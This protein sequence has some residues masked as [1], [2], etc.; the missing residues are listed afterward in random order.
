MNNF[1]KYILPILEHRWDDANTT[2]A[3]MCA[4]V[5]LHW[6]NFRCKEFGW[7]ELEDDPK[8]HTQE[9]WIDDVT[10]PVIERQFLDYMASWK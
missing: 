6:M 2:D 9:E 3:G 7:P 1:Q 4:V 5:L 10:L 8:W